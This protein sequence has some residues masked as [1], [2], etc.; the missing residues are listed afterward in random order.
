MQGS[1]FANNQTYW[2]FPYVPSTDNY[3][4]DVRM[5]RI[6]LLNSTNNLP[7]QTAQAKLWFKP[8]DDLSFNRDL[9]D[10]YGKLPAEQRFI[11]NGANNY[12]RDYIGEYE[13]IVTLTPKLN[14]LPYNV[15]STPPMTNS[16]YLVNSGEY[17]MSVVVFS[18]RKPRL[19]SIEVN[20]AGAA[21]F[22]EA[23]RVCNVNNFLGNGIGGGDVEIITRSG[24]ASD[25]F[26]RENDWVMLGGMMQQ[27]LLDPNNP[28]TFSNMPL[29]QWYRVSNIQGESV[30]VG[31]GQFKKIVTLEGADWP[32]RYSNDNT[33]L[34]C[35]G[36]VQMTLVSGV[37]GVFQ[38]TITLDSGDIW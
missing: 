10:S 20:V 35:P 13:W 6:S 29:F 14:G 9:T 34:V 1:T 5:R 22:V 15:P 23:E 25:T 4:T 37:V 24:Y 11:K 21:E 38:R 33:K 17:V 30:S 32:V 2:R 28:V 16:N 31:N 8:D 26:V 3:V 36:G 19:E 7:L 27:T 18:K 12:R